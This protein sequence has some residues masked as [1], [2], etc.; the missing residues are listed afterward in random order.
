MTMLEEAQGI[1]GE[2]EV[3]LPQLGV[4][5]RP[6]L[7]AFRRPLLLPQLLCE[8]LDEPIPVVGRA[9]AVPAH[10]LACELPA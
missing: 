6:G 8:L 5:M 9:K 10:R 4:R 7:S 2:I 3:A 1:G